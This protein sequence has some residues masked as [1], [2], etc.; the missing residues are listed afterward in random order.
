MGTKI[1]INKKI[2]SKKSPCFI[3]AEAGVNHNGNIKL[4][5]KLIDTAK[6]AG[7]DAIKF[8]TF[9]SED[10][11]AEKAEM[12]D[13]QKDNIKIKES[14]LEMLKK[15]ELSEKDF[16]EL[17]RY[18]DKKKIIFLSTPHT[19][20]A[21]DFLE[22]LVP[23]YKI[24]SG[25]LTNIPFL[26][27]IAKKRKPIILSTGMA[28][29]KEVKE[30]IKTIKKQKNNKIILLHCTTNY[31]T[32]LKEVNLMAIKTM[33]KEF[34]VSI[35]YSDHT[36][37]INVSLAAVALGACVIE[38]HL[39]LDKNMSGPDHKASLEPKE[40]KAL[41]D[42]I[43][44]IEKRIKEESVEDIVKILNIG[45]ALGSGIKVPNP[46]ELEVAKV[47]RKSIIAGQDIKKGTKI[48]KDMLVIKRPGIGI[49]PKYL[50]KIINKT[51]KKDIKK[52]NLIKFQ[53]I[54]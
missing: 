25:D 6:K 24:G 19:E 13:Y 43:R 35:G 42:G 49:E 9:K 37:N 48:K 51:V 10:L 12:A 14:Q 52:D 18:C 45:E 41:V 47:A 36:E 8:Q 26:E 5:K 39:T 23:V 17:K 16:R 44:T 1:K 34:N 46:S 30:A 22:P 31:P 7:V 40:L 2:I 4:A 53:D 27:R 38:K 50:N 15:L 33:M 29:L 11:V 54:S 20:N 28:T 32:P 21:V 3:I